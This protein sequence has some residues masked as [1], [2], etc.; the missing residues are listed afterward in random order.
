MLE[1][2][3]DRGLERS[4]LDKISKLGVVVFTA[5]LVSSVVNLCSLAV[6]PPL[7]PLSPLR[8]SLPAELH[9]QLSLLSASSIAVELLLNRFIFKMGVLLEVL[10]FGVLY[11]LCTWLVNLNWVGECPRHNSTGTNVTNATTVVWYDLRVFETVGVGTK[12]PH[13]MPF[14]TFFGCLVVAAAVCFS[15]TATRFQCL[16]KDKDRS[17]HT[18][19]I[20]MCAL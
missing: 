16:A 5:A 2:S 10:V 4:E 15:F 20:M 11:S 19:K 13:A 14:I 1:L 6:A 17:E 18:S 7:P 9:L 8:L 12:Y 3:S